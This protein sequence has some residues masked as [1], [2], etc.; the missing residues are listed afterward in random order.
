MALLPRRRG[1]E[2]GEPADTREIGEGVKRKRD[3]D[4]AHLEMTA[5]VT[6]RSDIK[7]IGRRNKTDTA[8][9]MG[10]TEESPKEDAETDGTAEEV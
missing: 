9:S 1:G 5:G 3:E 2:F 4:T 8:I 6:T 10:D 7:P